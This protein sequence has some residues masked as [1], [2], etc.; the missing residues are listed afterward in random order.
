M[1]LNQSIFSPLTA[2]SGS[3]S[4]YTSDNYNAL[5]IISSSLPVYQ[6]TGWEYKIMTVPSSSTGT[7]Q[8]PVSDL[9]LT[10]QNSRKYIVEAYLAGSTA[11][12][13]N[14]LRVGISASLSAET[15]YVIEN[16]TST[17]AIGYSFSNTNSAGSGPG[18]NVNDYYLVYIKALIITRGTGV[19]TWTPTIS[20]ENAGGGVTEVRLGPSVIYYRQ[21]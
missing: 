13:A 20:S 14:G 7:V 1:A 17:T 10:L 19:P 8:V 18:N 6:N 21:Y 15:H 4:S 5:Q 12:S 2:Y 11:A 3:I 16:P 9:T